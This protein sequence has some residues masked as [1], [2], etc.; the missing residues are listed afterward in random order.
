M[1]RTLRTQWGSDAAG[2]VHGGAQR[3]TQWEVAR[4]ACVGR[5]IGI[6]D[7]N[8]PPDAEVALRH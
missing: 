6:G 3:E 5:G 4:R 7:A 2:E 8:D 1:Q